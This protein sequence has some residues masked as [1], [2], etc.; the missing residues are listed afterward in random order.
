MMIKTKLE[1]RSD[2]KFEFRFFLQYKVYFNQNFEFLFNELLIQNTLLSVF[3][4]EYFEEAQF[5]LY[6]RSVELSLHLCIM[7]LTLR[8]SKSCFRCTILKNKSDK[9]RRKHIYLF[10][11][12]L[13]YYKQIHKLYMKI[14]VC[15]GKVGAKNKAF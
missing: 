3:S 8:I 1:T 14:Y 15:N 12:A 6:L 9:C 11:F 10:Y 7:Y 4:K 5:E 2:F 13:C